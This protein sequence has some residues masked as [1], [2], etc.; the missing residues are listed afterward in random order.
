MILAALAMLAGTSTPLSGA[1]L[2]VNVSPWQTANATANQRMTSQLQQL[3]SSVSMRYGGGTYADGYD[4]QSNRNT[5]KCRPETGNFHASCSYGDPYGFQQ[6]MINAKAVNANVM[7]IANYGSGTP[8]MAGDWA[9]YVRG[10]HNV[11]SF[12]IGNEPYGCASIIIPLTKPPTNDTGYQPSDPKTCPY[13]FYGNTVNGLRQMAKS[14]LTYAPDFINAIKAA[15]PDVKIEFP[16]AISPAHNDGWAWNQA[17]LPFLKN[18]DGLVILW[19]PSYGQT[20]LTPAVALNAIRVIPGEAAAIR[21]DVQKYAP[22]KPWQIG[23][24]NV[25]NKGNTNVCQ[26]NGAVFATADAL[27]WLSEGA[28][29][30]NWWEES[31]NNNSDG[32]CQ[33]P[34][35]AM[36]DGTG[37]AQ[38][39]YTGWLLASKLAQPHA[40]LQRVATSSPYLLEFHSQ[41]ANGHQAVA[42]VN[43]ST[44]ITF[45]AK[46]YPFPHANLPS[47]RY[48]AAAPH[49]ATGHTITPP[50]VSVQPDSVLVLTY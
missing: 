16:Y 38:P 47:F 31:D 15:N 12:E 49:I 34:D 23:E 35:F 19:Y 41:L 10:N 4:W 21:A 5:Y 17:T 8:K 7:P 26:P 6:F 28:S 48:S 18:Y 36:F 14:Y 2:G 42:Y 32:K 27:S 3:G 45:K 44:T 24:T 9:D 25:T 40:V 13:V 22:G 20:S 30:V 46:G 1:P 50:A 39:P 29:N 11:T 43:L 37:M 33:T